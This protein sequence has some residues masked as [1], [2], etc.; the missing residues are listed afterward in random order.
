MKLGVGYNVFSGVEL[1]KPSIQ[2]IR[3]LAEVVVVVY[4]ERAITGE[5]GVPFLADLL[6][7]MRRDGLIDAIIK[8]EHP[9]THNPLEIQR[10]KRKKYELARLFCESAGCTN[11]MGRDC[12]EFFGAASLVRVLNECSKAEMVVCPVLDYVSSPLIRAR[13]TGRL[14]V[15]AFQKA[16]LPYQPIKCSVLV[17]MSRTVNAKQV[18][19][20]SPD[21]LV[22]HHMTGV[23]YNEEEMT[24][25]FQGHTHFCHDGQGVA[26]DF[27]KLV[28][29]VSMESYE[30]TPD[31]FQILSYWEKEFKRYYARQ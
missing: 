31:H 27:R 22:M 15:T 6:H 19:V 17:D 30:S 9:V 7:D 29:N 14:H 20:L 24:R 8:I 28:S 4:S 18:M 16:S 26:N 10:E 5:V 11:F 25:K 21:E 12:D 3:F 13:T 1:L 23:R 2:C